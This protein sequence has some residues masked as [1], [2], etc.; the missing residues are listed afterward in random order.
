VTQRCF[1][2]VPPSVNNL[3]LSTGKRRMRTQ[4]YDAWLVEAII[5]MQ[6]DLT[7]VKVYPVAVFI[8][9]EGGKNFRASR[10]IANCEK[11]ATDALVKAG[12]LED[13]CIRCLWD[14]AQSYRPRTGEADSVC[15]VEVTDELLFGGAA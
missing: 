5:R 8:H 7:P 4:A 3:F 14:T 12:I 11:A 2:P 6:I 9:V 10:D 13:D 15:Y 1:I